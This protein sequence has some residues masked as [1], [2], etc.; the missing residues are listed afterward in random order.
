MKEV[1]VFIRPDGTDIRL[2]VVVF[3]KLPAIRK[4]KF[5]SENNELCRLLHP[6]ESL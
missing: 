6:K 1:L 2:L 4:G 3:L 5:T